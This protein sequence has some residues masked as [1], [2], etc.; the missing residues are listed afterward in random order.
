VTTKKK[1]VNFFAP[2][3]LPTVKKAVT[4]GH[5]PKLST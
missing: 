5:P 4:R 1:V 2:L 3:N